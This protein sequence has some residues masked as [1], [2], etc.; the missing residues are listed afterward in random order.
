MIPSSYFFKFLPLTKSTST[1]NKVA[2]HDVAYLASGES[3]FLADVTTV[4]AASK[5]LLRLHG[6]FM[7]AAWL[8]AASVG[9]LLARYYRQT[10]VGSTICGKDQWFAVRVKNLCMKRRYNGF[11][12][13]ILSVKGVTK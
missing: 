4:A 2:Y 11:I 7:L 6:A 10:W 3:K 13:K 5:L 8:G 12:F 1:A 9:I